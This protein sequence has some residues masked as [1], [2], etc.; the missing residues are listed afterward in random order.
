MYDSQDLLCSVPEQ[1]TASSAEALP[2]FIEDLAIC[3]LVPDAW[4]DVRLL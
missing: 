1:H 4:H 2:G 3:Q